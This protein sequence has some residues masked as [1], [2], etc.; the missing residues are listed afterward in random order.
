MSAAAYALLIWGYLT[1]SAP[2]AFALLVA[3]LMGVMLLFWVS[4]AAEDVHDRLVQAVLE[5]SKHLPGTMTQNTEQTASMS[6]CKLDA[7]KLDLAEQ[8]AQF[9]RD[10]IAMNGSLLGYW[11]KGSDS[12]SLR[13]RS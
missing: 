7:L 12:N 9:G 5:H 1:L 3:L 8:Y 13:S 4:E 6:S 2:V 11:H 10:Q